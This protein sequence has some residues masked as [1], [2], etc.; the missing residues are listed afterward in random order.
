MCAYAIVFVSVSVCGGCMHVMLGC[1]YL[2]V[3]Q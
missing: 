2:Y 1:V 3:F